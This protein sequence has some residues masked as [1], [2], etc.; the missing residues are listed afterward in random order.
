MSTECALNCTSVTV[1]PKRPGGDTLDTP[2]LPAS[3]L[4]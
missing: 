3:F 1:G 2:R 4:S